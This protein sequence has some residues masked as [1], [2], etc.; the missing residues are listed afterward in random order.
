MVFHFW[1]ALQTLSTSGN[2]VYFTTSDFLDMLTSKTDRLRATTMDTAPPQFSTTTSTFVNFRPVLESELRS[3][4]SAVNLKS[5]ELDPLPPFIIVEL[6]DDVAPF[7]PYVFNRSLK[8][9]SK[10]ATASSSFPLS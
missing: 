1:N 2:A 4:L 6:L 7:L 10:K 8:E 3:V 9:D 5:C